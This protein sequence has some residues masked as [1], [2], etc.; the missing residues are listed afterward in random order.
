MRGG[1]GGGGLSFANP[2]DI[3][4]LLIYQYM[5]KTILSDLCIICSAYIAFK[6]SLLER[7]LYFI[8]FLSIMSK[9]GD[10]H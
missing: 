5:H 6:T 3:L 9:V 7:K 2:V 1:G 8:M 10:H 4:K